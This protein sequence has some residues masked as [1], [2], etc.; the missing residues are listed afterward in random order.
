MWVA[1]KDMATFL[2]LSNLNYVWEQFKK[3]T[4]YTGAGTIINSGAFNDIPI[5]EV[6]KMI[7][8]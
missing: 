7:T 4:A 3:E 5:D 8:E 2:N 1:E 6:K